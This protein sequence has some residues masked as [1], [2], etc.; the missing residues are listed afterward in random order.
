MEDLSLHILDIAENSVNAGATSIQIIIRED[1]F[2]D[3]LTIEIEDNGAGMTPGELE[4]ASD[5]FYTTRTTRKVGLGLPLLDEAARAANGN[6][7]IDSRPGLGTKVCATFQ[8]SHID[9]KPVG[10]MAET[11]TALLARRPDIDVVYRHE[12][13]DDLVSFTTKDVRQQLDGLPL[14]SA[15]S[16]NFVMQYL[17]QEEANLEHHG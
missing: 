17:A 14:N 4:M 5:P 9:R 10:N 3:V 11:I 6:L 13:G 8:L 15:L 7:E 16:L 12:R 1:I 2:E